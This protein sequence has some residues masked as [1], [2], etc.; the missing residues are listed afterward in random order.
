MVKLMQDPNRIAN[1]AVDCYVQQ[2]ARR[3][4]A[5]RLGIKPK[6][7]A[8]AQGGPNR[9]QRRA[10]AAQARSKPK[11][12]RFMHQ[13]HVG[14]KVYDASDVSITLGSP[15]WPAG[16]SLGK[17]D[18]QVYE[19]SDVSLTLGSPRLPIDVA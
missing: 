8:F 4:Q 14:G 18:L 19:E 1:E 15:A 7:P 5:Q 11:T 13:I 12:K 3:S 9:K 17:T 10:A 2:Q 6:A 16:R